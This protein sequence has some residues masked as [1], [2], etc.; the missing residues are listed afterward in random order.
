MGHILSEDGLKPDPGKV[1]AIREMP[2]P[3]D[4]DGVRSFHSFRI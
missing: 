3:Q 2:P 4:K 1:E